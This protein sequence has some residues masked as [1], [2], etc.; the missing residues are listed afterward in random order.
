MCDPADE[1]ENLAEGVGDAIGDVIEGVGDAASG[2]LDFVVDDVID[3][4]METVG[5]VVEGML[6]DPL[7]TIAQVAAVATGNAWALPLIEGA[8]VAIAGAISATCLKPQPRR[9]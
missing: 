5:G 7:K 3:P 8:D 1:L 9:T 4:V 2:L 6:D